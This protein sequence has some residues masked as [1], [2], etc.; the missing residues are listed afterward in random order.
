MGHWEDVFWEVTKSINEKGLR[1]EF[2]AQLKKMSTQK[3]HQ[4]K[5]PTEKWEYA[6]NK[7]KSK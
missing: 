3:K 6:L 1:K 5:S 4:W 2:D 7:I